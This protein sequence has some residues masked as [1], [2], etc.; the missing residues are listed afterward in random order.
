MGKKDENEGLDKD[1]RKALERFGGQ[2]DEPLASWKL[3]RLTLADLRLLLEHFA[4]LQDLIRAVAE[5]PPAT[6]HAASPAPTR[7]A[8]QPAHLPAQHLAMQQQ[9]PAAPP[10]ADHP[11]TP[12]SHPG[13]LAQECSALRQRCTQ[14][15]AAL[16]AATE[17]GQ[18]LQAELDQAQ[19][20]NRGLQ[21]DLLQCTSA[22]K[23]L[24]QAQ[25]QA[26][27]AQTQLQKQLQRAQ[28][29]TQA[30]R[31]ELGRR[32]SVPELALLR[33][34]AELAQR[35][36]LANLPP[37]DTQALIRTVAVLAQQDSLLRLWDAIK[38]RCEAQQRSASPAEH[39]LLASALAWH[40]HNWATRPY[41]LQ[42]ADATAAYDYQRHQRSRHTPTG[43]R[44]AEQ[45]LPGLA[46][47][48]GKPLRKA[49]VCT[50]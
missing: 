45:R 44:L 40:N 47:G 30:S 48:G 21:A 39:T 34:D 42:P 25:A 8:H 4:P 50:H 14:A 37:D 3:E 28:A 2:W 17:H 31:A 41:Q 49:L 18:R 46:D 36:E 32:S 23:Q 5:T 7:P 43:E 1:R 13:A 19:A 35:L 29:E 33:A 16:L 27:Q 11:S 26:E 10:D 24:Q 12:A 20:Q 22:C 9:A 38:E 6:A 15:E